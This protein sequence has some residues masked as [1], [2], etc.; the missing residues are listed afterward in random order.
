MDRSDFRPPECGAVSLEG[1]V[2]TLVGI[3]LTVGAFFA[4]EW[5][6]GDDEGG[7]AAL[8]AVFVGISFSAWRQRGREDREPS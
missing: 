6:L 8:V 5:L 7:T 1:I 4:T 3:A 2:T